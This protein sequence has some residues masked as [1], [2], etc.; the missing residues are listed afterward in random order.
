MPAFICDGVCNDAPMCC[1]GYFYAESIV[2]V[3]LFLHAPLVVAIRR[4][5]HSIFLYSEKPMGLFRWMWGRFKMGLCRSQRRIR[6][7]PLRRAA[8]QILLTNPFIFGAIQ[9]VHAAQDVKLPFEVEAGK[10]YFWVPIQFICCRKVKIYWAK[11]FLGVLYGWLIRS[12][13]RTWLL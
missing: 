6:N 2:A 4:G 3:R 7:C 1:E 9:S 8:R 10:T 12:Q 13:R 11:L 5:F